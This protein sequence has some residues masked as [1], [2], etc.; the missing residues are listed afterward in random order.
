MK[1]LI[2]K[3]DWTA[4]EA[5]LIADFLGGLAAAIWSEYADELRQLFAARNA[6]T[7]GRYTPSEDDSDLF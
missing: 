4:E 2:R 7:T 1:E 3:L 6:H 5:E